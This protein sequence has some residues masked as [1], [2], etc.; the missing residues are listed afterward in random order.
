MIPFEKGAAPSRA[1]E[2]SDGVQSKNS[3]LAAALALSREGWSVFPCHSIVRAKCTCTKGVGCPSPGKHPRTFNGSADATTDEATIEV[4]WG[5]WPDANVAVNVGMSGLVVVDVDR[6]PGGFDSLNDLGVEM[7]ET[8]TA[9]TGGA[10]RHYV[11]RASTA[12]QIHNR[13]TWRTGIDV[14]AAPNGYIVVAPSNHIS[15]GR[16]EW[17]NW[18]TPPAEIPAD[19][20]DLLPGGVDDSAGAT[21]LPDTEDIL[22]GVPEG[23]RDDVLFRAACRWRR[24]TGSKSAVMTLALKAASECSPPLSV[25]QATKCVEQAFAQDHSDTYEPW[26]NDYARGLERARFSVRSRAVDGGDFIL[27]E[28]D[29]I[30]AL[31]GEKNNVLWASGEAVM[32]VGHQG[33]GKTTIAQQLVLHRLGLRRENFLGLP[34]ELDER[35]ILY[36][37]M[38]RPRQAARSF[39]RMVGE[40]D[41]EQL[42]S[43]LVVWRGPLPFNPSASVAQLADFIEEHAPGVGTVIVDSVKDLAPG[44]SD[45][46]VGAGLNSAWQEIVARDVELMLLHHERK[47]SSGD[48]RIH[49]LDAVYGSTWLTSG[50]GSVLVLDGDPG[51]PTVEMR[52]LKQPADPVGPLTLRHD[53]LLGITRKI[54]GQV[55]LLAALMGMVDGMTV[56]EAALAVEGRSTS[57]DIKKVSRQL[58][59]LEG[60]ML[61]QKVPG[62]HTGSGRQADRWHVTPQGRASRDWS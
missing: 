53:H 2:A 1:G 57:A 30:P 8:L 44:I 4:W 56:E 32:I 12:R 52:H 15:G 3:R 40:S 61:V 45:D 35:P 22:Q 6:K 36:L 24:Q 55:D 28:P 37:A 33:V 20:L 19:L 58:K 13:N 46:K 49:N 27:D 34:V 17:N 54:E 50:L 60:N 42:N 29:V 5:R 62:G 21:G 7:P 10:G 59:A 48:K 43:G 26:M 39:R 14:K 16:Y 9:S 25:E 51:D 31:W 11:F 47:A 41:R 23:Q 38:D 18:G